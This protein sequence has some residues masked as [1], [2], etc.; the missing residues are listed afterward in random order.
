MNLDRY[1]NTSAASIGIALDE[2]VQRGLLKSGDKLIL[3][4]FG[5]G[6]TS[7]AILVEW[8]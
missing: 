6:M 4:G 1:G 2:M 3:V 7:G 5:G 8:K